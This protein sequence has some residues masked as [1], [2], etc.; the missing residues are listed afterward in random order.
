MADE[1]VNVGEC[2]A[3]RQTAPADDGF[4]LPG[5]PDRIA[6]VAG[7]LQIESVPDGCTTVS[8]RVPLPTPGETR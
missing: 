2:G 5:V 4:G 8:V 6:P 3:P 1:P 7:A